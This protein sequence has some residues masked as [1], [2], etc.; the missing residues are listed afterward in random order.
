M[1]NQGPVMLKMY[2]NKIASYAGILH[3]E[4]EIAKYELVSTHLAQWGI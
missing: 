1:L 2:G 4:E 3:E